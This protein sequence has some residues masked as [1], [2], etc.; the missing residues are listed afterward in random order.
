M[1]GDMVVME[2]EN[3]NPPNTHI[4]YHNRHLKKKTPACHHRCLENMLASVRFPTASAE[5]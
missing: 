3:S 5:T 2:T 1:S 4:R